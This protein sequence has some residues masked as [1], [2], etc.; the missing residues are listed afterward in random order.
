[1]VIEEFLDLRRKKQFDEVTLG[2]GKFW[3]TIYL[4]FFIFF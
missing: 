3:S 1:M 2:S 4:F